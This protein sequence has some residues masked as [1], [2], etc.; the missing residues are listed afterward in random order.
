MDK[1]KKDETL[2]SLKI[3]DNT[4]KVDEKKN[5]S[6]DISFIKKPVFWQAISVVLLILFLV[7]LVTGFGFGPSGAV[8]KDIGASD[9]KAKVDN[10]VETVLQG[11]IPATI[12]D[13]VEEAGLY[14]I[15]IYIQ[16]QSVESY[17]TKDGRL[18]FPNVVDL[19]EFEKLGGVLPT[20]AAPPSAPNEIVVEDENLDNKEETDDAS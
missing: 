18:F 4:L 14:K 3:K 1:Q 2:V 5:D 17:I 13:A 20:I 19:E 6:V 15:N 7:S 12:G 16:G 9:V 10:Y 11:R 8:V